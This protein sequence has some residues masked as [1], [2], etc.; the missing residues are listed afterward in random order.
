MRQRINT[1]PI[2]NTDL[3][4]DMRTNAVLSTD[5]DGLRKYR[6]NRRRMLATKKETEETKIRLSTL[7]M[8]M[9]KLR[10]IIS[11]LSTMKKG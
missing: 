7:E 9:A 5:A 4:R 6:E 1:V 11:D 8:E 10:E 2:Q 3:V